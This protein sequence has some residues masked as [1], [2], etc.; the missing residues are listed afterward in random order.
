MC[1]MSLHWGCNRE[2]SLPFTEHLLYTKDNAQWFSQK[3][4][5]VSTF[6]ILTELLHWEVE[7]L[8]D[9]SN[10]MWLVNGK[11]RV[12]TQTWLTLFKIPGILDED[13]PKNLTRGMV[14]WEKSFPAVRAS[15][16]N[17]CWEPL[18]SNAEESPSKNINSLSTSVTN[19]SSQF[20]CLRGFAVI[21]GIFLVQV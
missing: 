17:F 15:V 13:R 3:C 21:F 2:Q 11:A 12:S 18:G 4:Y 16:W 6:A 7:R 8:H 5:E 19:I 20:C 9:L 10:V 14:V 1:Q